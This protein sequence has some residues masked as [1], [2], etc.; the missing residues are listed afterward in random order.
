MRCYLFV[1]LVL[2]SFAGCEAR[3][4]GLTISRVETENSISFFC[5]DGPHVRHE[6]TVCFTN[7]TFAE[8]QEKHPEFICKNARWKV[9]NGTYEL[10]VDLERKPSIHPV[11]EKTSNK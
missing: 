6:V 8:W 1:C 3:N 10:T 7:K 11:A 9:D 5:E 2:L 4:E